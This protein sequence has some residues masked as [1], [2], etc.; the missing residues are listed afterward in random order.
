[1][2]GYMYDFEEQ[3]K[4]LEEVNKENRRI[5]KIKRNVAGGVVLALLFSVLFGGTMAIFNALDDSKFS[6]KDSG[7]SAC[8]KMAENANKKDVKGGDKTWGEPEY[9]AAMLPF[10]NSQ[11]AD[12]KVAG[13][14]M[15]TTI[16]NLEKQSNNDEDLGGALVTLS[17]IQT[18]WGQ[19]Q[20]ACA[21][22]GVT[23]PPL[24]T[25]A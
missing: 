12:I 3:N 10:E 2:P 4:K 23:V 14:N 24:P 22:H 8:E 16:Y 1:M 19:L 21:N 18:Q 17:T 25:A 11:H 15:V 6:S 13:T 5:R 9:Q 20:T 7:I